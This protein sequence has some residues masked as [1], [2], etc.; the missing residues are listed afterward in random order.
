MATKLVYFAN[1][2][3]PATG[4]TLTWEYLLI[5]STGGAYGSSPAF[6]EV[7]GGWYKFDINPTEKLVGVIDGSATLTVNSERYQPV[8]FDIYDYLW[9]VLITPQYDEDSDSMKFIVFLLQNGK[10]ATT[11]LTNC[12]VEVYDDAHALL[13]TVNST[14]FTGGV[15]ILTKSAPGL[16]SNESYYAKGYV[17]YDGVE[18]VSIDTFISLE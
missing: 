17:T 15:C 7:G 11:P 4:L 8:Y 18:H 14:S 13:F 10:L 9:E 16:S 12:D 5:A 6:T 2:G 1:A 3:V